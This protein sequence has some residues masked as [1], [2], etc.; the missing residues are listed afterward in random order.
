MTDTVEPLTGAPLPEARRW[1]VRLAE[2]G[3]EEVDYEPKIEGRLP[4]GL[5][6]TLYRNGPGLFERAGFRKRNLLDG[7]GLIRATT[8]AGG[9][10]RFRTRFVRT[11]KFKAEDRAGRFLFPTWTTPAPR[12][13]ANLP[14]YPTLGQAG[15]TCAVKQ[16]K[17][18]ALD[19]VGLPYELSPE[20]LDTRELAD[21]YC[22]PGGEGPADY[23]AHTKTDGASGHWIL[24]GTSGHRRPVLH[25]L[26]KD[27]T[28]RQ[29][30]HLTLPDPRREAYFHDFFWAAPYAVFHL[31]PAVLSPLPMLLGLRPFTDSLSWKPERGGLLVVVDT[32]G[33]R[34]PMTIEVPGCWMWHALNAQLVGDAILADFVGYEAPDHFLGPDAAFRNLMQGREGLARSPG[35]LRRFTID[36]AAKRAKLETIAEGRFEFPMTHPGR[37]GLSYRK[38][39]VVFGEP[40]GSWHTFGV[41]CID[42]ESGSHQAFS[43]G[44]DCFVGEPVFVPDPAASAGEDAGWLLCEVLDGRC[45]SSHLAVLDARRIEDGPLARV[46]LCRSLPISFHGWWEAG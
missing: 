25:V 41:A 12:R 3:R 8:F 43:F 38:G 45:G 23:K 19:E 42:V 5:A 36:L 37:V 10:A 7:D 15:V 33:T 28:G 21:P 31:H 22:G 16:G 30:A 14:G 35:T 40:T 32:S 27:R 44:D 20:S 46:L 2:G 39:Y 17:L 6:G 24:V 29:V 13:L 18:Y 1:L 34:T 9:R 11:R 26:V 4:D